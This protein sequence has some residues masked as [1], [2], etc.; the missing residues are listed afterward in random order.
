MGSL[1]RRVADLEKLC[2]A[3]SGNLA[4]GPEGWREK[5]A[6]SLRQAPGSTRPSVRHPLRH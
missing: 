4:E 1:E 3:G 6:A 2:S 5:M